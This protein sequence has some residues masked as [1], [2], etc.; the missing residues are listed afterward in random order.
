MVRQPTETKTVCTTC[1][2]FKEKEE[3]YFCMFYDA[4]LAEE[5]LCIPCEFKEENEVSVIY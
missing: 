1:K 2:H 3:H 4:F 5:T